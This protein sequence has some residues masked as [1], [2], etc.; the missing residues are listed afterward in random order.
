MGRTPLGQMLMTEGRIDEMQLRSAITHQARFGVRI[1]AALVAMGFVSEQV[2]LSALGRQ[3]GVPF[4]QIGRRRVASSVVG[5]LPARIIRRHRVFPIALLAER[6]G[7]LIVAVSD[8]AN[9][10]L[11]DELAFA[12][13]LRVEPALASAGDIARAIAH[14]LDGQVEEGRAQAIDVPADPGPMR[15]V[16]WKH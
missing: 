15:L 8:P 5:A 14:H 11:L 2:M 6:R 12:T 1:G 10:A 9:L 16:N 13:G 7:P 4:V 3:L